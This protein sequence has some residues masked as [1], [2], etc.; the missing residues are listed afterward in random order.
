M[1][2]KTI[3]RNL[4]PLAEQAA[5]FRGFGPDENKTLA[6]EQWLRKIAA[7]SR[8]SKAVPFFATR[9]VATFFRVP[10]STITRVYKKLEKEGLLLCRRS[11]VTELTATKDPKRIIHRGIVALPIWLPGFILFKHWRDFFVEL[12]GQL[13]RYNFVANM[14]FY[15]YQ[16]E[17]HPEYVQRVLA[18][19]PEYFIWLMPP[20][21]AQPTLEMLADKGVRPIILS[22]R[23]DPEFRGRRYLISVEPG[24]RRCLAS[25]KQ[26][27]I[28]S[29]YIG[30]DDSQGHQ[31]RQLAKEAGLECRILNIPKTGSGEFLNRLS[32]QQKSGIILNDEFGTITL[33]SQAP[34]AMADLIRRV[35]VL[36]MTPLNIPK[37]LA[38]AAHVD[39]LS[40]DWKAIARRLAH[41]LDNGGIFSATAPAII[42]AEWRPHVP[43][44]DVLTQ[45]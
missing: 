34:Q 43:V 6:V 42:E 31:F 38:E 25:W 45:D 5:A 12:E 18:H 14:I 13:R 24:F 39:C 16:E 27:G 32:R 36:T 23:G 29:V 44:T 37:E 7:H 8:R 9:E 22:K 33:C 1:A 26:R 15:N 35:P 21:S 30:S 19:N 2:R 4:T 17:L 3:Q 28:A 41:D 20:P 11:A 10:Q 40:Y